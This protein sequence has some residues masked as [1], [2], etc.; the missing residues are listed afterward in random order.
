VL[1]VTGDG[2]NIHTVDFDNSDQTDENVVSLHIN[3]SDQGN[4]S[5]CRFRQSATATSGTGILLDGNTKD[6]HLGELIFQ[7]IETVAIKTDGATC[8]HAI[9]LHMLQGGTGIDLAG[10]SDGDMCFKDIDIQRMTT[11]IVITGASV[12]GVTFENIDM[13]HNTTN[14]TSGG[15]YDGVH[16]Q[17][18]HASHTSV[19]IY[20]TGTGLTVN[21]GNGIWVWT[22][23]PTTL[24]PA[25]TITKPF[26]IFNI[27]VQ[28][29]NVG[30]T[31]KIELL[32]GQSVANISLGKWE[33]TVGKDETLN[34]DLNGVL[35]PANSIIGAKAMSSTDDVDNVIFTLSYIAI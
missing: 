16:F 10:A 28:E 11:G 13:I 35:V 18:V 30:Q 26:T 23:T 21:T 22:A 2:F 3:G 12:D 4:I 20:P 31:F 25:S 1:K 17:N 7:D 32:Y 24:I 6:Y 33:F 29:T 9:H 15:V 14:I 34:V 5:D 8:L 19:D 27:N